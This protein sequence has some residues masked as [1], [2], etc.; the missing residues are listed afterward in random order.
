MDGEENTRKRADN[1]KQRFCREV[2]F[3][4]YLSCPYVLKFEGVFYHKDIPAIV[5]PWMPHGN[6]TEYLVKHPDVDW[7]RLVSSNTPKSQAGVHS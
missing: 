1:D 7:L 4:R 3:W 5:T 6:I 2:I